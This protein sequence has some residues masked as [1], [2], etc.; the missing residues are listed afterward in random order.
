MLAVAHSAF[1]P[2]S[3]CSLLLN[4]ESSEGEFHQLPDCHITLTFFMFQDEKDWKVV[5]HVKS[6]DLPTTLSKSVIG[7]SDGLRSVSSSLKPIPTSTSSGM[8]YVLRLVSDAH[9][10]YLGLMYPASTSC[11]SICIEACS[12]HKT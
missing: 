2:L 12:K 8:S 5:A 10:Q 11:F 9:P 6:R 4:S 3:S 7:E 1:T